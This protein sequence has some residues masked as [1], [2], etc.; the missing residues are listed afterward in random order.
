MLRTM[1][2]QKKIYLLAKI[3]LFVNVFGSRRWEEMTHIL[4]EEIEKWGF[5]FFGIVLYR[6]YQHHAAFLF[7]NL[8]IFRSFFKLVYGRLTKRTSFVF[9]INLYKTFMFDIPRIPKPEL[10][11]TF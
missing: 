10:L 2:C 1:I 5:K 7:V 11:F 3:V 4:I 6:L 9:T 8:F